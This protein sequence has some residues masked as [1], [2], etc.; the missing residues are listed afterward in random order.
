MAGRPA[1]FR[2]RLTFLVVSLASAGGEGRGEETDVRTVTGRR[3]WSW[4]DDADV[5]RFPDDRP[6]I[7]FD[8]ECV[9]CSAN[10]AFVLRHDRHRRFRLTTAQ[11][12]LGAALYRH[13]GL[14]S[15]RDYE[16]FLVLVDGRLLT[17]SDA[18]LAVVRGLGWPW[19]AAGAL[20]RV[21]RAV[22]DPLYRLIARNRF[23]LFGRRDRCWVAPAG[24]RE[25]VL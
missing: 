3:A 23:R 1:P 17:D 16:T 21:P 12:P 11:G 10:A 22:R 24:D 15:D 6:L 4:R 8:G 5:P 25:R 20:G 18:A 2:R 19:R 9:L 7:V 14:A 13:F